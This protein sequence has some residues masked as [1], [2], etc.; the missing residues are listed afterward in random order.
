MTGPEKLFF[1]GDYQR[2]LAQTLD[3]PTRAWKRE[4]IGFILGSLCFVGRT[5]EAKILFEDHFSK[6][7]AEQKIQG[8]FFL[9]L[10]FT[11]RSEYAA[12]R[13]YFG[14]NRREV[15]KK[16]SAPSRFYVFQG[17]SF[18][19]YF[20][21][22]WKLALRDSELSFAAALKGNFLY[23]R[24]LSSDLR[25][26]LLLQM[27]QVQLGLKT[28]KEAQALALRMNN[29]AISQ[30]I[31]ISRVTYEAQYGIQPR[32]T[33]SALFEY[34][35]TTKAVQDTYSHS[36]LLLELARQYLLRGSFSQA[37]ATLDQAAQQIYSYQ[38]RRQEVQLNL[39]FA[40]LSYLLGDSARGLSYVQAGKRALD[41]VVDHALALAVLGLEHKLVQ[42]L[43]MPEREAPLAQELVRESLLFGGAVN[44]KMLAR[45]SLRNY[46]GERAEDKLG[47][48]R[49]LIA[50]CK[51]SALEA[52]LATEYRA[53]LLD[54]LPAVRGRQVL[55]LDLEE[56]SL[57]IFDRGG[58]THSRGL[59]PLLRSLLFEISSGACTKQ[60]LIQSVWRYPNYH[61][62]HH[63]PVIY[64]AVAN[65][66]KL[67]GT[68]LDWVQT[69]EEGYRLKD[70]VE[71][72]TPRAREISRPKVK[73]EI[74]IP[75]IKSSYDQQLNFRQLRFLQGSKPNQFITV[76]D[77]KKSFR[78]S[79]ITASRDLALLYKLGLVVRIGRARATRYVLAEGEK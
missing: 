69:T 20:C 44:G 13:K 7:S 9:G 21:G 12:A 68:H 51:E 64:Q 43:K 63:D 5:S 50:T 31:E 52:V 22:K 11:R 4:D 48:L 29:Q 17:L 28:L 75:A 38:N 65:I 46:E 78:V 47:E 41:P 23:G 6:L 30:A 10:G 72:R 59:T 62:L 70:G 77:Y 18:Y 19:R 76:Q 60:R 61:P 33:M 73:S 24:V 42:D 3:H 45:L 34:L 66:R 67:L 74:V 2:L 55:Y 57:T 40:Y 25:G 14:E 54:I 26:H 27:G 37:A 1:Q 36:Q 71:L 53:F 39:R 8:R 56:D 16:L 58:I 79:E 35:E 15:R 49:D 32:E